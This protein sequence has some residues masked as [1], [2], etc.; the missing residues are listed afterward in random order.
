MSSRNIFMFFGGLFLFLVLVKVFDVSYPITITQSTK[1]E[2]AVTGEGKV[3]VIPDTAFIDVGITVNNKPTVA[4]VQNSINEVNNR[5]V[6]MMRKLG[7]KKEDIK[8]SNYSIYPNYSAK[9]I[10]FGIGDTIVQG[11]DQISG[12]NGNVSI[13]IKVKDI[14]RAPNVLQEATK[15]GAN[16]VSGIRFEVEDP[17]KFREEARNKAIENAKEQAEKLAKSLGIRLGKVVN[18]VE[19]GGEQPISVYQRGVGGTEV[20]DVAPDIEPGSQTITSVVTLYFEKK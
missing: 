4:E 18:I 11:E 10:P 12:Y 7:I 3:E 9:P 14:S 5:I 15:A 6:E 8:T 17:N 19:T 16:Q 1:S 2:L 20:A 13:S